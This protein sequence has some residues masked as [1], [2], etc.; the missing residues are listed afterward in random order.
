M[1]CVWGV[2]GDTTTPSHFVGTRF[3]TSC[4]SRVAG[5]TLESIFKQPPKEKHPCIDPVFT[6]WRRPCRDPRRTVTLRVANEISGGPIPLSTF[7]QSNPPPLDILFPHKNPT[8][9]SCPLWGYKFPW[10]AMTITRMARLLV[11][12]QLV[13]RYVRVT[14]SRQQP[15][16][17]GRY[18]VV[19]HNPNKNCVRQQ[20][21]AQY[22]RHVTQRT[23]IPPRD[24]SSTTG[25]NTLLNRLS[26]RNRT[27]RDVLLLK[28][29]TSHLPTK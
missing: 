3:R 4:N 18:L 10:A 13:L 2:E 25:L 23:R 15:V 20:P 22:D 29:L 9:H 6:S 14:A 21:P 7:Y 27:N 28:N 12:P 16:E 5:R 19:R 8:M 26:R 1:L 24:W 11:C 17:A